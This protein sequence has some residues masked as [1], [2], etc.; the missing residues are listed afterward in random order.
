MKSAT[1]TRTALLLVDIQNGLYVPDFYGTSPRSTPDFEKNV[2]RLLRSARAY[3]NTMKTE[4]NQIHTSD[5]EAVN[6]S[7]NNETEEVLIIHIHHHSVNPKS[8]LYPG[9]KIHLPASSLPSASLELDASKSNEIITVEGTKPLHFVMPKPDTEPVFTK[10]VNS[11]F[12]G[13]PLESLLRSKGIRQ[14]IVVGLVTDHCVSTTVRMAANLGVLDDEESKGQVLLVGDGCA[15]FGKGEFSGET[16]HKVELAVLHGEFADVVKT[17]E[18]VNEV[19][20]G[21]ED[22]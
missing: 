21:I 18:V 11:A 1:T 19:F 16:V 13:T 9:N 4:T 14:L 22:T 5:T 20:G 6:G 2:A 3:N 7:D 10:S 12:I 17:D 15:T 8:P